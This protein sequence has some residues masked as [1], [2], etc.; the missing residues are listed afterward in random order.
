MASSA[1]AAAERL[2]DIS[3]CGC[4]YLLRLSACRRR[5]SPHSPAGRGCRSQVSEDNKKQFKRFFFL[6]FTALHLLKDEVQVDALLPVDVGVTKTRKLLGVPPVDLHLHL[7]HSTKPPSAPRLNT[8]TIRLSS[9]NLTSSQIPSPT[10]SFSPSIPPI[11]IL[12]SFLHR[13]LAHLVNLSG[14]E[15]NTSFPQA[16]L[17]I[18][19]KPFKA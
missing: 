9:F 10:S 6:N 15:G 8:L 5:T 17:H 18:T 7:K 4:G 13:F 19:Q 16:S 12:P 1:R 14:L 3:S 11:H 2:P